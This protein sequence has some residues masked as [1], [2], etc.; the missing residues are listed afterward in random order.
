[1]LPITALPNAAATPAGTDTPAAQLGEALQGA[2]FLTLLAVQSG[3]MAAPAALQQAGVALAPV[4]A[5]PVVTADPAMIAAMP[6]P[7]TGKI[8]PPA[9]PPALPSILPQ[10]EAP[11]PA[12]EQPAAPAAPAAPQTLARALLARLRPVDEPAAPK[13]Q[14]KVTDEETAT[15]EEH[16]DPAVTAPVVVSAAL[17]TLQ[18]DPAPAA[19]AP[20]AARVPVA[21]PSLPRQPQVE[22]AP[23]RPEQPQQAGPQLAIKA[24]AAAPQDAALIPT[25]TG[26]AAP[27]AASLKLAVQ[28]AEREQAQE[29]APS[30]LP[31]LSTPVT[32]PQGFAP[33]QAAPATR[34]HDFTA[35]VDRLV[36]AR[37]AMQPQAVSVA[38]QHAEFGPVQLHFR[39]EAAG[40][41]V[42]LASPDPDFAR[43]VSAAVTPVQQAA[44]TDNASLNSGARQD[45]P[46]TFTADSGSQQRGSAMTQREA[47][48]PR[49]NPSPQGQPAAPEPGAQAGIFA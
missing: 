49:A 22:L 18:N 26:P 35:L 39:H 1:M 15:P 27:V 40:L 3:E 5:E 7:E 43:A 47:R 8:L 41:S 14:A 23:A 37:E 24:N 38:V 31:A 25:S 32:A 29:G 42:S 48:G 11:A 28:P 45:Q 9:L 10:A 4:P 19:P 12:P 16:N 21:L 34:P 17:P 13:A 2:E 6:L 46:G 44:P 33:V 20:V 36:A 30:L